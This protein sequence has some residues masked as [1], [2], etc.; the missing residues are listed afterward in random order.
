[1]EHY[2]DIMEEY[3]LDPK[4][5]LESS[6]IIVQKQKII[7]PVPFPPD[8]DGDSGPTPIVCYETGT[9]YFEGVTIITQAYF[10][11]N[12]ATGDAIYR[13]VGTVKR[14][15]FFLGEDIFILRASQNAEYYGKANVDESGYMTYKYTHYNTVTPVNGMGTV[16]SGSMVLTPNF[17]NWGMQYRC[18]FPASVSYPYFHTIYSDFEVTGQ[19]AIAVPYGRVANVQAIYLY[20]KRLFGGT[21]SIN[22]GPVGVS[23]PQSA[24]YHAFEARP[25]TLE[26]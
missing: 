15:L 23:V 3:N 26:V 25:L 6:E 16:H 11:G 14:D 13:I 22:L 18:S 7:I 24:A 1:M 9:D 5:L 20:N 4:S 17:V 2:S 19:Y 21:I 10:R 12:A 8:H